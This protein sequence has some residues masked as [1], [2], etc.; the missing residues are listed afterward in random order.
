MG[1]AM[2]TIEALCHAL[3]HVSLFMDQ[4]CDT[5]KVQ[6]GEKAELLENMK[7]EYENT[8]LQLRGENE[9]LRARIKQQA[10]VIDKLQSEVKK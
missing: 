3:D 9:A 2:I 6:L 8:I 1:H 10:A 5:L 4:E 7:S